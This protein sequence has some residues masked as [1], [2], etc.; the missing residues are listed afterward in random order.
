M[1]KGMLPLE[2]CSVDIIMIKLVNFYAIA[3]PYKIICLTKKLFIRV[4]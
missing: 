3:T 1:M 4:Q 2:K